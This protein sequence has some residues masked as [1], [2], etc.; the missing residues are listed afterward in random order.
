MSM[1]PKY[2]LLA[3]MMGALLYAPAVALAEPPSRA[4]M[5]AEMSAAFTQADA[6]G[7]ATLSTGEYA[8]FDTIMRQNMA[9]RHFTRVDEDGDGAVTLDELQAAGPGPGGCRGPGGPPPF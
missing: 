9:K 7:S 4:E 1:R 5:E 8:A 2:T 6:D 3:G